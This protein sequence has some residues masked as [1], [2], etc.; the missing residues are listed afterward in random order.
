MSDRA[1]SIDPR[2]AA[3]IAAQ[4]EALIRTYAPEWNEIDPKTGRARGISAALIGVF[5]RFVE[6][7]IQRLNQVPERN[8][9]AFLDMVGAT[10]LSPQAARVPLTF[11]L[12]E[13]AVGASVP[14]RT[15]VSVPAGP[16]SPQPVL[17]ET[18]RELI[19]TPARL[20]RV[21]S[22]DGTADRMVDLDV[23]MNADN[24]A[25][26]RMFEGAERIPHSFYISCDDLFGFETL[27]RLTVQV[28]LSTLPQEPAIPREIRWSVWDGKRSHPIAIE[29]DDGES[30]DGTASL[31]RDGEIELRWDRQIPV[32]TVGGRVG[33]WLCC[34]LITPIG[35]EARA[36]V[37]TQDALSIIKDLK[38]AAIG[39]SSMMLP[40][41]A[42]QGTLPLDPS[43]DFLPFGEKPRA[44]ATLYLGS[45]R[46]LAQ[47]N[48]RVVVYFTLSMVS[49]SYQYPRPQQPLSLQWEYWDGEIW[50]VLG[51]VITESCYGQDD[52]QLRDDTRA[53]TTMGQ[54]SFVPSR[55][56]RRCVVGGIE[57]RWIRVRLTGGGYITSTNSQNE[58][59]GAPS[60]GSV[61][62]MYDNIHDWNFKKPD[63][64]LTMDGMQIVPQHGEFAPFKP[65]MDRG[66]TVYL[67]FALP[68]FVRGFPQR[69]VSLYADIV[70]TPFGTRAD[71]TRPSAPAQ[72]SWSYWNGTQWDVLVVAD[73]TSSFT[74]PGAIRF[75]PP[76]D[77]ERGRFFG[78][79]SLFWIRV[80]WVSG[81]YKFLPR[82]RRIFHN[83]VMAEQAITV[84]HEI[85]GSG[86]DQPDQRVLASH[87]PLLD[88]AQLLV[89]EA[90]VPSADERRRLQMEEGADA[91][92]QTRNGTRVRWH[93]VPDFHGSSSRDRHFVLNHLT[94]EI[95]FGNGFNG[96][97][98]RVGAGNL[99]L[100]SYRTGGG[101]N[102]N[103]PAGTIIQLKTTVPYVSGVVNHLPA[104]GGVDAE[105]I[106]A[107][108]AR[109]P[110]SFRHGG[111]AVTADDF[112]DLALLASPEVA[113]AHTVPLFDLSIDPDGRMD[114]PGTVSVIIVPHTDAIAPIPSVELVDRVHRWLEARASPGIDIVVVGPEYIQ[115]AI[116]ATVGLRDIDAA[117]AI[118]ARIQSALSAFLHPLIGGRDGKGW[119]FGR[120]PNRS[121]LMAVLQSVKGVDHV[122][123]LGIS[124]V[125]A[126]DGARAT[127]RFLICS[128]RHRINLV[129][130]GV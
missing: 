5:S 50:R 89:L 32:S 30:D 124:Q 65:A 81:D 126:R 60:F 87:P 59:T 95:R 122:R 112:R 13:G 40:D 19:L 58:T 28:G 14:T 125:E 107:L 116:Q 84:R 25:I 111:R 96:M 18:E 2:T 103:V 94:G 74:L 73:E 91:I 36:G 119:S 44:G 56:P 76:H 80:S 117:A 52:S 16:S 55:V 70:E 3:H 115:V 110:T 7:V 45:D 102:G 46:A 53:L 118:E 31:T 29:I 66:R 54:I 48:R 77:I 22:W 128:G 34:E 114:S 78:A 105:P 38:V 79:D 39:S 17:F 1:P 130:A 41:A 120:E 109:A 42:F 62:F 20:Q 63:A 75:L 37:I 104:R 4:T 113:R 71:R 15:Q 23:V 101:S 129:V 68:P 57:S 69:P 11:S 61:Y 6:L 121:D 49:G 35:I 100:E 72:L 21:V 8:R 26:F 83:T 67:G 24:E 33:R 64:I 108:R 92:V 27:A 97:T 86:N 43:R 98:P 9:M 47:P 10:R 12:A 93:E 85:L 82:L 51:T 90:D 127:G 123:E 88:G 106:E 99:I